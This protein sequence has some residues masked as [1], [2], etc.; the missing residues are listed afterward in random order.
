MSVVCG[1]ER[2]FF[3]IIDFRPRLSGGTSGPFVQRLGFSPS[4]SMRT[5]QGARIGLVARWVLK[6]GSRCMMEVDGTMK[7]RRRG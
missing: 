2:T 4:T 7:D 1:E 3:P 5:G 6:K